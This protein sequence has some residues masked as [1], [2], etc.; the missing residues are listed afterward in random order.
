MQM[1][2]IGREEVRPGAASEKPCRGVAFL[3]L[4]HT[5]IVGCSRRGPAAA[6]WRVSTSTENTEAQLNWETLTAIFQVSE[7]VRHLPTDKF[8]SRGEGDPNT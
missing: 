1:M 5:F 4:A 7:S 2:E 3:M 8:K 6:V